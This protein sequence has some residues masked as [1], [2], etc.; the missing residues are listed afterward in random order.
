MS[1]LKRCL[2]SAFNKCITVKSVKCDSIKLFRCFSSSSSALKSA[3]SSKSVTSELLKNLKNELEAQKESIK[4][5]PEE[6]DPKTVLENFSDFLKE[7]NWTLEHPEGSTLVTLK[8]RDKNLQ[9]DLAIKFDL[10]E[11][12]N[13]LS[14][15]E[16]D[17][18]FEQEQGEY[19]NEINSAKNEDQLSE[20]V[21]E[22]SQFYSLPFTLEI[23]RDSIPDK[24]LNFDCFI[25]G[26]EG[27]NE[28]V[29]DNAAIVPLD[30]RT[31]ETVYTSPNYSDLDESL[32]ENFEEFVNEL[33]SGEELMSFMTSY[34]VATEA[35][36]YQK[37]LN[38]V[39]NILK[40]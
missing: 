19:E 34:S 24:S 7:N 20:E 13:E 25:N 39:S 14:Q 37:W 29:I 8:R 35:G 16:E 5:Q 4:E 31:T 11:V 28:I 27:Q 33:V 23:K 30:G 15:S 32:Q 10:V 22:I 6:F 36:M 26:D 3:N 2:T 17:A 9:A 21:D 18:D 38:D 1:V 12:F 40:N